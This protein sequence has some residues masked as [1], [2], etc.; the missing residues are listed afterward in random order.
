MTYPRPHFALMAISSPP[1]PS[2]FPL[3]KIFSQQR[4]RRR[5]TTIQL[6]VSL[7]SQVTSNPLLKIKRQNYLR[8][9]LSI[10]KSSGE[11][12]ANQPIEAD[13]EVP[14]DERLN[15][16]FVVS[17]EVDSFGFSKG[18]VEREGAKVKTEEKPAGGMQM[19][20]VSR[21]VTDT[22]KE[23]WWYRLP[24]V[25]GILL[26]GGESDDALRGLYSLE[27]E[28]NSTN[29]D[30]MSYAITFQDR[31]DATHCCCVLESFFEG[32]DDVSAEII[33]FTIQEIKEEVQSGRL[34]VIVV[35]KG[36]LK[37]YAGQP[38]E[39]VKVALRSFVN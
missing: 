17:R 22:G 33:P 5:T 31:V 32:L 27:I 7:D 28:P 13:M 34:N 10:S 3:S 1:V 15:K 29:R 36:K 26:C 4:R 14:I 37:L 19:H 2:L 9:R 23:P 20:S 21:E 35:P 24:F 39:E 12:S 18:G 8:K 30:T 16:Q 6:I 11:F 25:I 38:L